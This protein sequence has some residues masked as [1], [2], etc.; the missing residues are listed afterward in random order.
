MAQHVSVLIEVYSTFLSYTSSMKITLINLCGHC[1]NT[2]FFWVELSCRVLPP[3]PFFFPQ[4]II[5]GSNSGMFPFYFLL[6]IFIWY[7][8]IGWTSELLVGAASRVWA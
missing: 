4:V 7:Q 6:N 1:F 5:I 2:F 3:R 8:V